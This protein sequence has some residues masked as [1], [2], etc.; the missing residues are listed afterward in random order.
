VARIAAS[1]L[2]DAGPALAE[3]KP[4]LMGEARAPFDTEGWTAEVKFDGYRLLAGV[5]AGGVRLKTKGGADATAWYPEL[6]SLAQ[7]AGQPLI[8][9]GEVIVQDEQGRSDFNRLQARSRHRRRP[10]G[11]DAVVFYVFDLL[12]LRGRDLRELPLSERKDELRKLLSK[13]PERVL[14]SDHFPGQ[15]RALYDH[16]LAWKFEGIVAKRLDSPYVGGRSN[17]WLKIKRPGAVRAG[18]FKRDE[19]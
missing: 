19:L 5:G 3:V 11:S 12:V 9:D 1:A 14:L 4:M 13:P 7:L 17:A 6:Q 2:V 16:A 8:L 10:P 15:V 18:S